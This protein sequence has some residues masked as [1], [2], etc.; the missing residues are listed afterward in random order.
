MTYPK[1]IPINAWNDTFRVAKPLIVTFDAYNTLYATKLPVMEQYCIVGRKYGIKTTPSTLTK[2]F[3]HVFKK[4][5][6]D[7]PQYGKHSNIKPEEWW[8][9]LIRNVFVPIEI[10]D[11]MIDE[12]LMRFEGFDSYFVYP[13]L[14]EFLSNLKSRYPNII[15]GIISNTDPTFY[16]LLKNIGLYETFADSIY[17]SYELDLI[18]PDRAMFQYALDDIIRKNS[19]L[20][21]MYSREEILQHSF[22]IGDE[23]KND[24]EGAQAAG[25]TGI[26]LDR[27]DKYGYLSESVGKASRDEYKLSIDKIDNHSMKTWEASTKQKDTVQLSERKYVVSN[28]EVLEELFSLNAELFQ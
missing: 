13:D 9:L 23:L 16:K 18:K 17:L 21:K 3:P 5:K 2:N 24:L 19:H 15:L 1:R 27:S 11:E 10:P 7:Y 12:I 4:L 20:L 8:S 25:W 26:L 28:F 22:H 6:E 14:I